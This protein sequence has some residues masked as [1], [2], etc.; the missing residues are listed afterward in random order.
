M[1]PVY[2]MEYYLKGEVSVGNTGANATAETS[3]EDFLAAKD[4]IFSKDQK[5]VYML[6]EIV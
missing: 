1:F 5:I 3:L 4:L 6:T 2:I